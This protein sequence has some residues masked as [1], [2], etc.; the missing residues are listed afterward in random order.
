MRILSNPLRNSINRQYPVKMDKH[1]N[2]IIE[3][4]GR[5]QSL[6]GATTPRRFH[7][8]SHCGRNDNATLPKLIHLMSTQ[9]I[10]L[11]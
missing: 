5:S 8:I 11:L 9:F 7:E 4:V 10:R 2:E 1:I 6:Q 3:N